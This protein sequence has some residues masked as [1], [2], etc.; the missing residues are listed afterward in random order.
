M[1]LSCG[2]ILRE[3]MA[4]GSTVLIGLI[5]ILLEISNVGSQF[6]WILLSSTQIHQLL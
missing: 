3:R 2:V 5:E 4:Q 6:F 1:F